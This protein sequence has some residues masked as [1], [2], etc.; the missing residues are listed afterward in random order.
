MTTARWIDIY[1]FSQFAKQRKKSLNGRFCAEFLHT[2]CSPGFLYH[3]KDFFCKNC[4]IISFF[5]FTTAILSAWKLSLVGWIYESASSLSSSP[6]LLNWI[7]MMSHFY[8]HRLNLSNRSICLKETD[9]A[10]LERVKERE[11]LKVKRTDVD[12][13]SLDGDNFGD[14]SHPTL[15]C[16]LLLAT[17]RP[18]WSVSLVSY[19]LPLL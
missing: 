8:P 3:L 1:F 7:M 18:Q 4:L 13:L 16:P 15:C 6:F 19:R 12:G 10:Q 9:R 2:I 14:F 11:G 5:S 17:F